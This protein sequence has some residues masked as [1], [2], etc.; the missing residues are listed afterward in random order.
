MSCIS[1]HLQGRIQG[2]RTRRSPPLKLEKNKI[3]WR[4][5]V[6]FFT[7]NTPKFFDIFNFCIIIY[8]VFS[9]QIHNFERSFS[10]SSGPKAILFRLAIY[11]LEALL[12][13]HHHNY[14]AVN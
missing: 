11:L 6:I 8:F 13:V 1:Q 4:K 3:F 10:L 12:P 5:I 7:R 14:V 9:T 2:G